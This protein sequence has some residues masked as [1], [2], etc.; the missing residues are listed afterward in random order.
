MRYMPEYTAVTK[1]CVCTYI[2]IQIHVA[3]GNYVQSPRRRWLD[4]TG[5]TCTRSRHCAPVCPLLSTACAD[6]GTQ[7][8]VKCSLTVSLMGH[9]AWTLQLWYGRPRTRMRTRTVTPRHSNKF[10]WLQT[11]GMSV[12]T[13]MEPHIPLIKGNY[14][15]NWVTSNFWITCS[16][17]KIN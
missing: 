8:A 4:V 12:P 10:N 13:V 17:S 11:I 6:W 3:F 14:L 9:G 2:Y 15:V 16:L 7:H 5:H 1:A